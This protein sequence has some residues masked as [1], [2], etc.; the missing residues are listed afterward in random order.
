MGALSA[1]CIFRNPPGESAGR[2]IDRAGLKGFRLGSAF[3][4]EQH[5]NFAMADRGGCATDVRNLIESVRD[6]VAQRFG[7]QLEPEVK[8]W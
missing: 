4:S 5:A 8:L 6:R 3:V 7:I 1:G 2:L